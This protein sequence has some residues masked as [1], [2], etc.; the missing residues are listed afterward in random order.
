MMTPAAIRA[1][2]DRWI[3]FPKGSDRLFVTTTSTLMFAEHIAE[4]AARAALQ[5]A[6]AEVEDTRNNTRY[7]AVQA[8]KDMLS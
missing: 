3:E 5:A 8:I 2:F 7:D 6:L 1:Q 4:L